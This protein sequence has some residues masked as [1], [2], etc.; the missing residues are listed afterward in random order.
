MRPSLKLIHKEKCNIL[1]KDF[2]YIPSY[3]TDLAR[4]LSEKYGFAPPS[5]LKEA[6]K[7]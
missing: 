2:L 4:V 1:N 5:R 3:K 7:P 6:K